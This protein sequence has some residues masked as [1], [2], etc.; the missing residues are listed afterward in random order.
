M[1]I[2]YKH[3]QSACYI[4]HRDFTDHQECS[5][6][7]KFSWVKTN[8]YFSVF[9]LQCFF[10]EC[11]FSIWKV[12]NIHLFLCKSYRLITALFSRA[13]LVHPDKKV[14]VALRFFKYLLS[15]SDMYYVYFD[16]P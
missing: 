11:L 1:T 5:F 3:E 8:I 13:C 10:N 9:V 14:Q 4:V 6:C 7:H 12:Q 2:D 16:F 15:L